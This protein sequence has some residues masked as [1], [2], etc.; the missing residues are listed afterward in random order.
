MEQL[1]DLRLEMSLMLPNAMVG[2]AWPS[3]IMKSERPNL[4]LSVAHY[5]EQLVISLQGAA[6][7]ETILERLLALITELIGSSESNE[8]LRLDLSLAEGLDQLAIS[9]LVVVLREQGDK[10]R[11]LTLSGLPPWAGD[12]LMKT[13]AQD[14][15]GRRW[16]GSFALDTASFYRC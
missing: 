10:F 9:A 11:R 1:H 4:R 15:L 5:G 8:H 2:G 13:G 7:G 12:R 6:E 14:L 3:P 16:S